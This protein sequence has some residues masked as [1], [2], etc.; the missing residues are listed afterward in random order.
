MRALVAALALLAS[1][2]A[3]SLPEPPAL[4]LAAH[5]RLTVEGFREAVPHAAER[6]DTACAWAVFPEVE[7]S[8]ADCEHA[9]LLF[10][11]AAAPR[12]VVLRCAAAPGTP[13]GVSYHLLVI[14]GDEGQLSALERGP[15]ALEGAP[16]LAPHDAQELPEA[17]AALVV[18]TSQRGGVLFAAEPLRQTL[19]LRAAAKD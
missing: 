17:E 2:C 6:L 9:G 4:D 11:R 16:H 10:T 5:C 13:G 7:D 14:L 19:E 15:L 8:A 18:V 3:G 1:A 12:P